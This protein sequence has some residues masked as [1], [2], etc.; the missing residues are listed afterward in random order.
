MIGSIDKNQFKLQK[1]DIDNINKKSLAN[2]SEKHELSRQ[3][4][5]KG[6]N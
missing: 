1:K 5:N 6:L 2:Y 4:Y 3:Q